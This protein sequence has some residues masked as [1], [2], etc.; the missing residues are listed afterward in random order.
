MILIVLD[1]LIFDLYAKLN[2]DKRKNRMNQSLYA[3]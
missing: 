3:S 1:S 2:K